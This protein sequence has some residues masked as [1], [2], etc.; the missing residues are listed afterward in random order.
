[1]DF[2]IPATITEAPVLSY[3]PY[4]EIVYNSS[5]SYPYN[6]EPT[7]ITADKVSTVVRNE[8]VRSERVVKLNGQ[9]DNVR[10]Y[11]IENY[12]EMGEE[13]ASAI[14]NLLDIE[15]SKTVEV[16]FDVTIKAT[17][18]LPIGQDFSDLSE[19]DFDVEISSNESD[20]EIE[21][22]DADIES[23]YER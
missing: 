11:L 14:A 20:Y 19:Y 9:I 16:K 23:M 6:V 17:I 4:A 21:D 15:L 1:M 22:F 10:E 18:S 12:E 2:P 3:D 8:R 7:K 5:T 13:H